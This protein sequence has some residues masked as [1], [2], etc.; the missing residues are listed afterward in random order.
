MGTDCQ[1][2][3]AVTLRDDENVLDIDSG[4]RCITE[5]FKTRTT[6]SKRVNLKYVICS[7]VKNNHE[8]FCM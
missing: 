2:G 1:W 4:D 5:Y 6:H 8:L 7:S 3:G